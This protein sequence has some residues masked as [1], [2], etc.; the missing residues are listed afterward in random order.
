MNI[1][2][3]LVAAKKLI[4]NP[5][6]W[7]QGEYCNGK[8]ID[9]STCFCSIGAVKKVLGHAALS[10]DRNPATEALGAGFGGFSYIA[11]YNDFHSHA[12]VMAMWDKAIEKAKEENV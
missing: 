10:S 6:N 7:L 12:E 5:E 3:T 9:V 4:E 8:D 2:E 1:Y 11:I